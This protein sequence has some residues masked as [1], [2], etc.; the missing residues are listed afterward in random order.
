MC[1]HDITV[2]TIRSKLRYMENQRAQ[3]LALFERGMDVVLSI[4]HAQ[5]TV[6]LQ[7]QR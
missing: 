4:Y 2:T 5:Q 6:K 1:G 7:L 3:E